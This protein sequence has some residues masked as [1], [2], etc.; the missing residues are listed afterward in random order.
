MKSLKTMQKDEFKEIQLKDLSEHHDSSTDQP[1]VLNI[2]LPTYKIGHLGF[3][4]VQSS[5][6]LSGGGFLQ[7]GP[8]GHASMVV[9][10]NEREVRFGK[11]LRQAKVVRWFAI[12]DCLAVF[13]YLI[14]LLYPCLVLLPAS[15]LGYCAGKRL[16]RVL[17]LCQLLYLTVTLL[18]RV[19]LCLVIQFPAFQVVQALLV[20]ANVAEVF[21]FARYFRSLGTLSPAER[22][23]LLVQQNGVRGGMMF[24]PQLL[25]T[26]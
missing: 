20:I 12:F 1:R 7:P 2:P 15:L 17:A 13:L 21:V 14:A 3:A 11:I 8:N 16:H 9:P 23:E 24:Q 18:L 4:P 10:L 26:I 6:S 22:G 19:V 5:S 25:H